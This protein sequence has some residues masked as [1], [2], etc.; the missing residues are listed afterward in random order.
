MVNGFF[1]E[2]DGSLR[3]GEQSHDRSQCGTLACTVSTQKNRDLPRV[4]PERDSLKDMV[5]SDIGMDSFDFED[6]FT[7]GLD[8]RRNRP[9]GPLYFG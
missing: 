1:F 2:Q 5:F 7:H 6:R 3:R 4:N 8:L 9:P